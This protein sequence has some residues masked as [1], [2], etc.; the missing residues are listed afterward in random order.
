MYRDIEDRRGAVVREE[1]LTATRRRLQEAALDLFERRG[2]DV[3]TADDIAEAAGTS[4]RTF[5]R[6]F[7]TKEDAAVADFDARVEQL[8]QLLAE[9]RRPGQSGIDHVIEA[10]QAIFASFRAE[11]EFYLKR[12]RVV[13]ASEALVD[14]MTASDRRYEKLIAQAVSEDFP[15]ELGGLRARMFASAAMALT[16]A[17]V[18]HWIA[19][20]GSDLVSFGTKAIAE[21]RRAAAA[22]QGQYGEPARVI[23]LSNSRLSEDEIRH[24][25][26]NIITCRPA[27]H[28]ASPP[29]E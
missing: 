3:V 23:I 11:P 25:L 7:A 26:I 21:L 15:G 19:D 24:R 6:H 27:R 20:P 29:Q 13:F 5:F 9:D 18:E 14:R 10:G 16:N 28:C 2:F 8:A 17:L 1:S 22:W 12:Y 4:R